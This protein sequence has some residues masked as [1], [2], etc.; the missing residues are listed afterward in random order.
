MGQKRSKMTKNAKNAKNKLDG[1]L[2]PVKN[3]PGGGRGIEKMG[4]F[5]SAKYRAKNAKTSESLGFFKVY[6]GFWGFLGVFLID[7][8]R[9]S[10]KIN[11]FCYE[12]AL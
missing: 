9:F 3:L 7:F 11:R 6:R 10:L 2:S 4:F 1:N 8:N 5:D 12:I